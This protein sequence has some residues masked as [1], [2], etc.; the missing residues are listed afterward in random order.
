M[1][2]ARVV[3]LAIAVSTLGTFRAQA[4]P[5]EATSTETEKAPIAS[6]Q[7]ELEALVR[8][9]AR[10]VSGL[11]LDDAQSP[12]GAELRMI[13][14]EALALDASYGGVISDIHQRQAFARLDLSVGTLEHDDSGFFGA[15][16]PGLISM[17]LRPDALAS[18][19]LLWLVAD[20][21]YRAAT[22]AYRAKEAALRDL[23]EAD[24]T[25]DHAARVEV[26]V[27]LPWAEAGKWADPKLEEM[28]VDRKGLHQVAAGL[29]SRF[30]THPRIDNG[31]VFIQAAR[32]YETLVDDRGL[33]QGWQR[34]RAFIAV[35]AD[36][37]AQDGMHL[38]H[39]LAVHLQHFPTPE[40]AKAAGTE[41]VD[42]VL[43]ELEAMLDAPM[44]EEDYDGPIL[45]EP[46]A[47]AQLWA[48]TIHPHASGTP[49]PLS[50]WGRVL[51][52]EPH[53]LER[54]GRPVLPDWL[55]IFDD[56]TAKGFGHYRFD[57][58]GVAAVAID[59]V[60]RG[61]LSDLLM[62]RRP[63]EKISKSNGHARAAFDMVPAAS[64]SNL[65]VVSR[66]RGLSIS[67]LERELLRRAR[68]DG[69]DYAYVITS[70]R[71]GGVLGPVPRDAAEIFA[72]G[73]KFS[74]PIPSLIYRIDADGKRTLVRGALLSPA[75]MR[76]LRR[77]REVGAKAETVKMRLTPGGSFAIDLG[78]DALLSQTI[79]VQVT[80]P[81]L[82]VD[83]LELVLERGEHDRLPTL[84]H[85]LRRVA[86]SSDGAP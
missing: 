71:D 48:S 44:L 59:L 19:R 67:R 43:S 55:S 74:L 46:I 8:E 34:D 53:W 75:S 26:G 45:F 54:L 4:A 77:I 80:T 65:E 42:R 15:F 35:V 22:A 81:A 33:G 68:E 6:G 63:N 30:A 9:L 5:A 7:S 37:R 64:F 29:S 85:P 18:P 70:L 16:A 50:E 82:L 51:E 60:E 3:V 39:G 52:L 76:V 57:A 32:S 62:T 14:L 23:A 20:A 10:S 58:Q 66:R 49:A 27:R 86:D 40:E 36:A 84:D 24:D 28:P 83:G 21:S 79:D 12:Y 2:R 31:D 72:T 47:A 78:P 1:K 11:R 56:P 69:Y 61:I 25:P 17:P 41:L 38:D 13:R 73:R